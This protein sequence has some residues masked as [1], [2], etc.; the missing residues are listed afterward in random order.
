MLCRLT[1]ILFASGAML[2]IVEMTSEM[3]IIFNHDQFA[4]M[5]GATA[6][7]LTTGPCPAERDIN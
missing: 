2:I 7:Y 1:K 4:C 5:M 6:T 3:K